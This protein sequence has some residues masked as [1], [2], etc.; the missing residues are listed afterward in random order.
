MFQNNIGKCCSMCEFVY[1]IYVEENSFFRSPT[2][3]FPEVYVP[4]ISAVLTVILYLFTE[5][6]SENG[7][8]RTP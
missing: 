5:F 3:P 7:I 2:F 6:A 4:S 1:S 8:L